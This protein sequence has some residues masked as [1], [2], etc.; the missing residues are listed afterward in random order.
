MESS[1]N[2]YEQELKKAERIGYLIAAHLKGTLT[3]EEGEELD[4]WITESDENLELFENLTDEDNIEIAM[5]KHVQIE[6]DLAK[7]LADV[8][9]KIHSNRKVN[10][11]I[12]PY[13]IAASIILIAVS[14]Y[15]FM[16]F[17]KEKIIENRVA[18][19]TGDIIKAGTDRAVLTLSDGRTIILDSTGKG[20]LA[21][22][23]SI[24]IQKG[25]EDEIIYNG[26]G[27][28]LIYNSINT[29]RGGQYKLVLGDG[30]KVWLN[31]ATSLKFPAGMASGKRVV[32]LNGEA[33][34][35][36]AKDPGNPFIVKI[37]SSL[38]DAGTVEVLGT[39]FNINSYGDENVV[40][41]TLIEGSVRVEKDGKNKILKPGEQ[42]L[43]AKEIKVVS[44]DV[45][46]AIAWKKDKFLFRDATVQTIGEQIKRWY[47]V[48][49][50]Y[51]GNVTQ[52]F[53]LEANRSISLNE[54]LNGLEGTG[55]V[56]FKLEGRKLIIK[57]H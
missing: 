33:Y 35:E 53:N 32:E 44:T 12:L 34:F 25:A 9:S 30:T 5:K 43:M 49:V 23:G 51:Q 24:S 8:K 38:G 17:G 4:A 1:R 52:H 36:V 22:E 39:H 15:L 50:E 6:K 27:N 28:E 47:D 48:E 54:L 11:G 29:P 16:P 40:K 31:A 10:R 42:A 37:K 18:Q 2:Q 45:N 21:E 13:L 57:S 3:A 26:T 56:K 19:H 14:L 7:A 55:Q 41:A 20:L 46:E